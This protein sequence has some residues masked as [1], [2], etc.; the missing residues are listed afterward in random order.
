[1]RETS[2]QKGSRQRPVSLAAHA[3][4]VLFADEEQQLVASA[5]AVAD[6]AAAAA[7]GQVG[8]R[9]ALGDHAVLG[10]PAGSWGGGHTALSGD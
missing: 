6:A 5:A 3:A 10:P 7:A 9:C 4:S 2:Y 1:M 8:S